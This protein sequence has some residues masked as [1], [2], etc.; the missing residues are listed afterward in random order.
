MADIFKYHAWT[1]KGNLDCY[2]KE[3]VYTEA[4]NMYKSEIGQDTFPEIKYSTVQPGFWF[5]PM[6]L[7]HES[8]DTN[9]HGNPT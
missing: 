1:K 9:D 6:H 3:I 5:R 4:T 7:M 8:A 2:S